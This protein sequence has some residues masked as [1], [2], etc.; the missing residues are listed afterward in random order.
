MRRD[1]IILYRIHFEPSFIFLSFTNI[2]IV[3]TIPATTRPKSSLIC[4]FTAA[5]NPIK[6]QIKGIISKYFGILTGTRSRSP[7]V[8]IIVG[9]GAPNVGASGYIWP[10]IYPKIG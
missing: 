5:L 9:Q 2:R 7:K 8:K 10:K 3:P 4:K 6:D 1:H